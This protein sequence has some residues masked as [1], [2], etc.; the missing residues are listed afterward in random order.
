MQEMKTYGYG[1]LK[2]IYTCTFGSYCIVL[3]CDRISFS[4]ETS[5]HKLCIFKHHFGKT[6]I[7]NYYFGNCSA[8]LRYDSR[9]AV[10]G[11]C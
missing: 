2:T 6:T 8:H 4:Q 3:N 10:N 5:P 9:F 11:Y 1:G 7:N